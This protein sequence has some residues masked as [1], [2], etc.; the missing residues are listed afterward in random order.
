MTSED[1]QIVEIIELIPASDTKFNKFKKLE[2]FL[3]TFL[4]FDSGCRSP[5]LREPS[6]CQKLHV[7]KIM[8]NHHQVKKSEKL[9]QPGLNSSKC[10]DEHTNCQLKS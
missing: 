1:P 8:L 3:L 9:E 4:A 2:H 7:S 5:H 10:I 6:F